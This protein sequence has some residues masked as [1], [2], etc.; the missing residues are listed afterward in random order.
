ML[1]VTADVQDITE[2]RK[3]MSKPSSDFFFLSPEVPVS[4][5]PRH[6]VCVCVCGFFFFFLNDQILDSVTD[7]FNI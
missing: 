6:A 2:K 7:P 3:L 4:F 5:F 1:E